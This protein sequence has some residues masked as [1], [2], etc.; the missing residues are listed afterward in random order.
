MF[1]NSGDLEPPKII[2]PICKSKK[3]NIVELNLSQKDLISLVGNYN[4]Y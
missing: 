4:F 1:I 3:S 2:L